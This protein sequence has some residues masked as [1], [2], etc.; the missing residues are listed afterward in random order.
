M[1]INESPE[2]NITS[3]SS[4]VKCV[5]EPGTAAKKFVVVIQKLGDLNI[6]ITVCF[7]LFVTR[8]LATFINTEQLNDK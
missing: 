2:Y 1:R 3:R 8:I 5:C 7:L 6:S 4:L